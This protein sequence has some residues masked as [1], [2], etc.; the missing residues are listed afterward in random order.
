[1]TDNTNKETSY[2]DAGV[3]IEKGDELVSRLKKIVNNNQKGAIGK[4][5]G[6]GG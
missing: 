4:L 6:F 1:M 5:G 3:S 2:K